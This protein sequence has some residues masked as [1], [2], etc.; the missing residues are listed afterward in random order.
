VAPWAD[1]APEERFW[2]GVGTATLAS[3]AWAV[4]VVLVRVPLLEMEAVTA[5]AIRLPLAAVVLW[6]TPWA[7]SAAGGLGRIGGAVRARLA[8]LSVLTALSSVMFV[9]SVKYAG[10][11]VATVLSSTAPMFAI[12]LARVFVGERLSG[13]ALLGAGVAVTGIVVLQL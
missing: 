6:A 12:P 4:S 11:A 13:T 7:R 8:V 9:A 5:Q 1:R 3:L 10:V 2:F